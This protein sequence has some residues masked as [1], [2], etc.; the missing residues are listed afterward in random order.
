[1]KFAVIQN[2][3]HCITLTEPLFPFFFL[4]LRIIIYKSKKIIFS[5]QRERRIT[6]LVEKLTKMSKNYFK[7]DIKGISGRLEMCK[8]IVSV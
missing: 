4:L 6:C 3:Y 8:D 1:M 7:I 5:F 2:K